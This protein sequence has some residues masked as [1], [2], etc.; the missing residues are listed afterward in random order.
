MLTSLYLKKLLTRFWTLC[1]EKLSCRLLILCIEK[2]S[3]RHCSRRAAHWTLP[4]ESSLLDSEHS[5]QGSCPQDPARLWILC[6]GKLLT[7]L[8][9]LCRGKL[10]TR[11]FPRKAA[12]YTLNTMP[13][14]AV[15]KTLLQR[16]CQL[17]TIPEIPLTYYILESYSL[18][19]NYYW[20]TIK[21][22]RA[23]LY[24]FDITGKW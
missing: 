6:A 5:S 16:S 10:P 15:R 4:Q 18:V 19:N 20:L 24:Y 11:H 2:L 22:W 7:R 3:T 9:T 1:P 12:P 8:S 13:R 23:I 17:D 21:S 14:E